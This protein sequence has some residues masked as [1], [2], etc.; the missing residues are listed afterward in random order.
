VTWQVIGIR[1]KVQREMADTGLPADLKAEFHQ[2]AEWA[3]TLP[4]KFGD[5]VRVRVIDAASIEGFFKSLLRRVGRYPAFAVEGQ[6]YVGSDFSRVD[7]LIS[8]RLG[9][10]RLVTDR[11][12]GG[13]AEA[14][15]SRTIDWLN[16]RR[17]KAG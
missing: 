12:G 11:W 8:A 16:S 4:A 3:G 6:R 5:R 17:R 7:A 2:L 13:D 10:P 9:G 1:Q 14:F 15:V